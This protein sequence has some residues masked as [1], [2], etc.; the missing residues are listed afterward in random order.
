MN[1][2]PPS[3][4]EPAR[5][6]P[7]LPLLY[8]YFWPFA[9]FRDVTRGR[10]LERQQNYRH[11][12]QMRVHLPG[13]AFKWALLTVLLIAMGFV[14]AGLGAPDLLAAFF[15]ASAVSTFTVS[16]VAMTAWCWL[17]RFPELY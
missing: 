6:E 5:S 1:L 17:T 12:R 16:L 14:L 2:E 7:F 13:F 8:R 10:R 11:N 15:F 3:A 4:A 9:C